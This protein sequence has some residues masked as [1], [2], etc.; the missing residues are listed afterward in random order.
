MTTTRIP[1]DCQGN[2]RRPSRHH[3][4]SARR[5]TGHLFSSKHREASLPRA[6][7]LF[8]RTRLLIPPSVCRIMDGQGYRPNSF[9]S[10]RCKHFQV[11]L[12]AANHASRGPVA[13]R[14][15]HGTTQQTRCEQRTSCVQVAYVVYSVHNKTHFAPWA[16]NNGTRGAPQSTPSLHPGQEP[17]GVPYCLRDLDYLSILF[18]SYLS[19]IAA[20]W[21]GRLSGPGSRA[22]GLHRNPKPGFG[23]RL[24][25][26]N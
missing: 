11:P 18:V 13:A 22:P 21:G 25:V 7:A 20:F 23:L 2:T 1:G 3:Q 8:A 10:P 16:A 17:H 15:T 14:A 26:L 19:P 9:F 5:P 12:F 6:L 4:E 24:P